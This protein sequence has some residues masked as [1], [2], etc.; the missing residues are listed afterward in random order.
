MASSFS[1]PL[2]FLA[3]FFCIVA[4]ARPVWRTE[5]FHRT[6]SGIDIVI[7]LDISA[8]M[9]IDDFVDEG[10]K[11][12]RIDAAKMVVDDFIER[13]PDD[14]IGLVVFAGRPRNA[15]PITLDHKWLRRVLEQIRLNDR[16]EMGTVKEQ[17]TAIGSAISAASSRLDARDAKS[18]I[19]VLITDGANNSG[20]IEPIEAAELAAELCI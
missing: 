10:R 2:I 12:R 18:K 11:K 9:I 20:K 15:S 19:I 3:I 6:A 4:M 14:R 13:R 16:Y 1:V 17:G 7:T 8:S 5:S